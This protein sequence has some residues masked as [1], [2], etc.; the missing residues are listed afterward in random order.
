MNPGPNTPASAAAGNSRPRVSVII[1]LYNGERYLA[2]CLDSICAQDF[3]DLEILVADDGS[4]DESLDIVK[5]YAAQDARL[6]W[7]RNPQNLGQTRNHNACLEAARGEFIKFVHQDDKL[8]SAAAIRKMVAALAENPAATLVGSASDVIDDQSRRQERRCDFQAGVWSGKQII[9]A[10]LEAVANKIG[11]PSVV[12]F[13]QAQVARG[14]CSDYRQLWDLEMWFYL[15]EQ[16]DF[17]FLAEPLSAFR[18]HAAQQSQLNRQNGIGQDE[19]WKLL[20]IYYGKAWLRAIATQRMLINHTRFLKRNRAKFGAP[21]ERMLA[22]LKT[23]IKPLSY[24]LYWLERKGLHQLNKIKRWQAG[25]RLTQ[26]GRGTG[27]LAGLL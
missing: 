26:T 25:R 3:Q 18:Q 20:E 9:R 16:G 22:E 19:I 7:W 8:L 10:N 21:A 6:R 17:V 4:T 1:P 23:H 2:E 15:L 14:F 24:P 11:E 12:M 5:R 27:N 13:R